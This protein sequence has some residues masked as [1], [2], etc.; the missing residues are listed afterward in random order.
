[1]IIKGDDYARMSDCTFVDCT[2]ASAAQAAAMLN[3]ELAMQQCEGARVAFALMAAD[4]EYQPPAPVMGVMLRLRLANARGYVSPET[5][6]ALGLAAS[7]PPTYH[8]GDDPWAAVIDKLDREEAARRTVR[9]RIIDAA[10]SVSEALGRRGLILA[11]IAIV[12]GI[13]AW[14]V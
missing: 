1:M 11:S 4:P 10:L 14:L 13:V 6:R 7:K 2:F 5:R 9:A 12:G 8:M 3:A